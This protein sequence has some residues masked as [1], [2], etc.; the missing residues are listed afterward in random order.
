MS[1][2]LQQP[3]NLTPMLTSMQLL[4]QSACKFC[5]SSDFAEALDPYNNSLVMPL[6]DF[7]EHPLAH[8]LLHNGAA[9]QVGCHV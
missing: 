2:Q 5:I 6:A 4:Y 7:I 1:G 3:E 8:D 9:H